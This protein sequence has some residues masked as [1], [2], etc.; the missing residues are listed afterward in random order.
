MNEGAAN[1]SDRVFHDLPANGLM[2]NLQIVLALFLGLASFGSQADIYGYIDD[3]G[4]SHFAAE[5]VDARY[6]LLARGNQFGALYLGA[7]RDGRSQLVARLVEHPQLRK[8]ESMLRAASGEFAVELALLK[9]VAAAESGF[10][11][12]AV[13]PKGAVGLMQVMPATAARYGVAGDGKRSIETKLRDP[14]TNIR[15]GARYLADLHRLY[16]KQPHLVLASY[17]AG[18]GAVRQYK[19]TVPPYP[20]TRGYVE[21]VSE[22]QRAFRSGALLRKPGIK[23]ESA[24]RPR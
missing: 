14:Q 10:D 22:L 6:Q 17:N 8:Y 7:S 16:P 20:E 9:A 1:R 12:D 5:K 19:D 11:P 2:Q 3:Q 21:L 24:A 23:V 15:L 4:V 13:S 18:E